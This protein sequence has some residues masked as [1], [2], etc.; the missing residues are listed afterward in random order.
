[1]PLRKKQFTSS[2]MK[3]ALLLHIFIKL[4]E[5]FLIFKITYHSIQLLFKLWWSACVIVS[6]SGIGFYLPAVSRM[7][8]AVVCL[9][10]G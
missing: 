5:N 10:L 1:M 2:W 8:D 4:V 3:T 9:V 7:R 6:E